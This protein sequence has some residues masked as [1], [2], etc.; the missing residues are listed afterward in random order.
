MEDRVAVRVNRRA[1][2][3]TAVPVIEPV[4]IVR[5]FREIR[6]HLQ[7][8]RFLVAASPFEGGGE[9]QAERPELPSRGVLLPGE[10][11]RSVVELQGSHPI[12]L[13]AVGAA[14]AS[15]V[16]SARKGACDDIALVFEV[17][18]SVGGIRQE[19]PVTGMCGDGLLKQCVR[20]MNLVQPPQAL[21]R[22]LQALPGLVANP[23]RIVTE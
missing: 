12:P 21:Q 5:E 23:C 15:A 16:V 3:V 10:F 9:V 14:S 2:D 1:A 19:S 22:L 8:P 17:T 20:G 18:I 13:H 7:P 4:V 11:Q 6:Q